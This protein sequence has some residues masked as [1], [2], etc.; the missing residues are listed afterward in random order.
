[1]RPVLLALS[2]DGNPR[3][4][5]PPEFRTALE[6]IGSLQLPVLGLHPD[7]SALAELVRS[8]DIVLTGHGCLP[9]PASLS[10]S[11][12]RL[13]HICGITG[14][15]RQ[16]VPRELIA[17]GIPLTN[18]GDAPANAI[19]EG[20]MALL[21]ACLKDLHEQ[22][23][24]VRV[25]GWQLPAHNH[26]G[27]LDGLPVGVY[28]CGVIGRRFIE[29]LRPFNAIVRVYDVFAID[30]PEGCVRAAT[31]RELFTACHA[32]VI[33]AGWTPR[34]DRSVSAELLSLLPDN[35]ILVNTARG[36]IVDQDAL[37][38]E[39]ASG[40][41][42]AGLDVLEPD[43][44]PPEHPARRYTRAIL[45]AHTVGREWPL[46]PG[47]PAPMRRMHH[48]ALEELRRFLAGLPPLRLVDLDRYDRST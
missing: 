17:A 30:L 32:V 28:G 2:P 46:P 26:G 9:L 36:G 45:T 4:L 16:L 48:Y 40:R 39:L 14:S 8:A 15:M 33:H 19:A 10:Q 20:A 27:S 13:R 37:F 29:L 47:S 3:C 25:G 31:L 22:V 7:P 1:M 35:G 23:L 44:L 5:A 43:E 18:W 34:T 11:P 24:N 12:G 42:R 21:L 41:I 38:A 6:S